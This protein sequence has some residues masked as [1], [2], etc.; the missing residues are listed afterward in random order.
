[1]KSY[2]IIDDFAWTGIMG[3]DREEIDEIIADIRKDPA[4]VLWYVDE[5]F[6]LDGQKMKLSVEEV[7]CPDDENE[8]LYRYYFSANGWA[9]K[10]CVK[11]GRSHND[12]VQVSLDWEYCP[13]CGRKIISG[14]YPKNRKDW[15]RRWRKMKG[16]EEG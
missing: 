11:C 5:D 1:M 12:D 8:T 16:R 9:D 15:I 4:S 3:H 2:F 14:T 13:W 7:E 6:N 10:V